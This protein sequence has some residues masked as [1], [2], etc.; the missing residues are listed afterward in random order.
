MSAAT[1]TVT[2]CRVCGAADWNDVVS[3][4]STPLAN[5]YLDATADLQS[6]PSYPLDVIRCVN[7]QL[8]CL[9]N[10]VSPDVL[11]RDYMYISPLSETINKHMSEIVARCVHDFGLPTH[12]LVVE[13]GSNNGL[14]LQLFREAGM[15]ILGVDPARNIQKLAT[16]NGIP[17]IPEFF[18]ANIATRIATHHGLARIII[19]RHVFAHIDDLT[20]VLDG[21]RNLLDPTGLFII[22]V[23]YLVDMLRANQ[24]DTIYHEHLSY[25]SVRTLQQLLARHGLRIVDVQHRNVHGGSIVVFSGLDNGRRKPRDSVQEILEM[26]DQF[27]LSSKDTYSQF[28]REVQKIRTELKQLL[29]DLADQEKTVVGYGAP[30]KGN[31]LLNASGVTNKEISFCTD[32]TYVKQGKL[33]PGSHIPI[34]SPRKAQNEPPDFYLLL[35]WNYA[36]E[37]VNRELTY[38][39]SGGQFIVP[40][41]RIRVLSSRTLVDRFFDN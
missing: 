38:L 26:E 28:A 3:L 9:R 6:E 21:V 5:S 16:H 40:I 10:V 7:C 18:G 30:A 25:F 1:K 29:H 23:P 14:Q 32:T 22:E 8:V 17:T 41:P 24:F 12:S 19:G 4:G 35:A 2:T 20:D 34:R 13:L 27:D 11:Y 33:L 36:N 15:Q 37:V 31:T 39:Q